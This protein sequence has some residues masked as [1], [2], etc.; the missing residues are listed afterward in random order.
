[1][2]NIQEVKY[3]FEQTPRT[4]RLI[5]VY[6]MKSIFVVF[7]TVLWL[8]GSMHCSLEAGGVLPNDFSCWV[9][10][11]ALDD[12]SGPAKSGCSY[13]ESARTLICRTRETTLAAAAMAESAFPPVRWVP[14]VAVFAPSAPGGESS[15]LPRSWQFHWRTAPVPRA[16]S[17]IS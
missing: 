9:F 11:A 17:S 4:R 6:R 1:M 10:P 8:A 12:P 16:P 13:E 7:W 5:R 2:R 3:F 14:T 15:F